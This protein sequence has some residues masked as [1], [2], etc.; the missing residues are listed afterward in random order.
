MEKL[1]KKKVMNKAQMIDIIKAGG[2]GK[3]KDV[4]KLRKKIIVNKKGK[5]QG[6][7]VDPNKGK[8]TIIKP[9]PIVKKVPEPEVK[10]KK[11]TIRIMKVS[12]KKF[13]EGGVTDKQ[14]A[15]VDERWIEAKKK[16]IEAKRIN[17]SPMKRRRAAT[18]LR[19]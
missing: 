13:I 2:A 4:S 10:K 18:A 17:V 5:K 7:W 1:S 6:V 3:K 8:T 15:T 16:N 11:L 19:Y 14:L 9:K 12:K